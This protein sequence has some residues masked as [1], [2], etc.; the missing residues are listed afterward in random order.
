MAKLKKKSLE[1]P[2]HPSE[3]QLEFHNTDAAICLIGGAV[4]GGKT[5]GIANEPCIR[6]GQYNMDIVMGRA[7]LTDFLRTTLIELEKWLPQ[8]MVDRVHK[9]HPINIQFKPNPNAINAIPRPYVRLDGT[10]DVLPARLEPTRIWITQMN[11]DE[12]IK[13]MTLGEALIDELSGVPIEVHNMIISRLR[14]PSMHFTEYRYKAGSNPCGGWVKKLFITMP[15]TPEKAKCPHKPDPHKLLG[16]TSHCI[17]CEYGGCHAGKNIKFIP[18]FV[19]D[20]KFLPETYA[21]NMYSLYPKDLADMLIAGS[22]ELLGG[23]VFPE[24]ALMSY[25]KRFQIPSDWTRFFAIDPHMRTPTHALWIAVSPAGQIYVYRELVM[26]DTVKNI[27][28]VI[29]QHEQGEHIFFRII[30]TS[31]NTDDYLTGINIM[32]EFSM[33]GITFSGAA[34][35]NQIGYSRIKEALDQQRIHIFDNCPNTMY[36]LKHL[37]WDNHASRLTNLRREEIQLWRKKDDHLFDCLKYVMIANPKY[38]H[39]HLWKTETKAFNDELYRALNRMTI[40][41]EN[42]K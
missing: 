7:D 24:V 29:R 21:S 10:P 19:K 2:Y 38:V 37:E 16:E 13:S 35:G 28:S 9:S 15:D 6:G 11:N 3:K 4:G 32:D 39:P 5:A 41:G 17:H 36:Q 8:Q 40:T 27:C 42:S 23:A 34:K 20:N 25:T 18:S 14:E 12:K 26:A 1:H 31:A 22:W 30:D 33:N